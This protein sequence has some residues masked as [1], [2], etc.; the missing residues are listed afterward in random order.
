MQPAALHIGGGGGGGAFRFGSV[1]VTFSRRTPK[2]LRAALH[3]HFAL[4]MV[5]AHTSAEPGEAARN[6]LD[7]DDAILEES[8]AAAKAGHGQAAAAAMSS[9]DA[10][11][12]VAPTTDDSGG[13]LQ[14]E[15]N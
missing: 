7:I 6:S 9:R 11:Q 14:V 13:A 4:R 1:F 3:R 2:S 8:E 15:S 12:L 10:M 5:A